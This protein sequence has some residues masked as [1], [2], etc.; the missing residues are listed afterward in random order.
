MMLKRGEIG[1]WGLVGW[2]GA[3]LRREQRRRARRAWW[4]T[5]LARLRKLLPRRC[6]CATAH[7]SAH[8]AVRRA[9]DWTLHETR[10]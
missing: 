9:V 2:G 7:G 3:G 10:P 5:Q 8:R 6:F 4:G 1:P